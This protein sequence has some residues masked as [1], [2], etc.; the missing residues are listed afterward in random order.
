M[1]QLPALL[2]LLPLERLPRTG[3]ILAGIATPESV[4]AHSLGTAFLVLSLAPRV[5]P[6][7][8]VDRAVA[9]AVVHDAPEARTGDLPKQASARLPSGAKDAPEA[10]VARELL[11]PLSRAALERHE[12][13]RAQRTREARFVRVCDA[14]HLGVRLVGYIR[15]GARGLEDFRPGLEGLACEGFAPCD[16]LRREILAELERTCPST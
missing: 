8:D 12:E 15:S 1:S 16:E 6:P 13:Y 9:L 5:S 3:W 2:E 4:A 14:L 10:A 7:L 11:G